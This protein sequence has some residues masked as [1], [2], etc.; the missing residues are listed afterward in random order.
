MADTGGDCCGNEGKHKSLH[1][2]LSAVVWS[3]LYIWRGDCSLWMIIIM[4]PTTSIAWRIKGG[5]FYSLQEES[6]DTNVF[7]RIAL[8]W[9]LDHCDVVATSKMVLRDMAK[10][11]YNEIIFPFLYCI[12]SAY[13]TSVADFLKKYCTSTFKR[14]SNDT[15][16]IISFERHIG[17]PQYHINEWIFFK[18]AERSTIYK[19]I[20][21]RRLSV[22]KGTN[23]MDFRWGKKCRQRFN[24][25]LQAR[26][27]LWRRNKWRSN[28]IHHQ[29]L[30]EYPTGRA[31]G[32]IRSEKNLRCSCC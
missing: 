14:K 2:K 7:V 13:Y 17:N 11:G 32:S 16:W 20:L 8:G 22:N 18:V 1:L 10:R 15:Q 29:G 19:Y 23:L 25:Q 9:L 26:Q 24:E 30:S 6:E 3:L 5:R 4:P 12:S 21:L 27:W 31:G 28:A